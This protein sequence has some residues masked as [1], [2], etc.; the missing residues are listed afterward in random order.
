M[1]LTMLLADAHYKRCGNRARVKLYAVAMLALCLWTAGTV[2]AQEQCTAR[3]RW[4]AVTLVT[5]LSLSS[6]GTSTDR[7][8]LASGVEL[9]DR[10]D[11]EESTMSVNELTEDVTVPRKAAAYRAG[12]RT[13]VSWVR[14]LP[15]GGARGTEYYVAETVKDICAAMND[16][17]DATSDRMAGRRVTLENR[18]GSGTGDAQRRVRPARRS[19]AYRARW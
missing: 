10:C 7:F 14:P 3:P 12:A 1:K 8:P 9:L 5:A 11:S 2:N 6:D 18:E 19:R 17:G 15:S 4:I 16:C 13:E